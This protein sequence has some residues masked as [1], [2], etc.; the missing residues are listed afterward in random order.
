MK[1]KITI[2]SQGPDDRSC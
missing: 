2:I 1:L